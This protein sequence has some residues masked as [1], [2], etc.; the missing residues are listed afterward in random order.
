MTRISRP[1]TMSLRTSVWESRTAEV[2]GHLGLRARL[3]YAMLYDEVRDYEALLNLERE[4]WNELLD[5]N[6]AETLDAGDGLRLRGLVERGRLFDR[7]ITSNWPILR[8][9]AAEANIRAWTDPSLP[10][11]DPAICRPL[12]WRAG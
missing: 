9:S 10:P 4:V 8:R 7:L 11:S 5:F 6:E 12:R 2:T 3:A 1:I